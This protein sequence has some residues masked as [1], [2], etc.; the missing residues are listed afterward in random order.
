MKT[1]KPQLPSTLTSTQ[2]KA[3]N[4]PCAAMIAPTSTQISHGTHLATLKFQLTFQSRS[5]PQSQSQ[6]SRSGYKN[7]RFRDSPVI[8]LAYFTKHQGESYQKNLVQLTSTMDI[9]LHRI[10]D[11]I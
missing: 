10:T 7:T 4:L 9:K 5:K 8:S 2:P 11:L 3:Q 6:Q 1:P